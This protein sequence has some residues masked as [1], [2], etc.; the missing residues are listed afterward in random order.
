MSSILD[1]IRK[2]IANEKE[3]Y[4]ANGIPAFKIKP[5]TEEENQ[6]LRKNNTK[7]KFDKRTRQTEKSVDQTEYV[8]D[9]A[10]A[11][12][13]YPDLSNAELQKA[14]GTPGDQKATLKKILKPGEYANLL[15]EI[16]DINGFDVD[17]EDLKDQAKKG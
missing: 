2:D 12:I 1:F 4:I 16:Q 6:Q 17:I 8:T 9:L 10:L 3:V 14:A 5:I 7:T 15:D 11:C 13:T